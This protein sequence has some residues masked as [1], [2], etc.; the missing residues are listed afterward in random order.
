MSPELESKSPRIYES[1]VNAMGHL[2]TPISRRKLGLS[3]DEDWLK[4]ARELLKEINNKH[5]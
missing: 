2:D 3:A 4:D 5:V 1:L